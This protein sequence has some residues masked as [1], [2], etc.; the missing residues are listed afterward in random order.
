M[1]Q[2]LVEVR[3][4]RGKARRQE[5][6]RMDAEDGSGGGGNRVTSGGRDR[7]EAGE[8]MVRKGGLEPPRVAP[9]DPKSV[10]S[11]LAHPTLQSEGVAAGRSRCAT[12]LTPKG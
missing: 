1:P 3:G 4:R 7:G 12:E 11:G 5:A 6:G 9:P 8:E 10:L 2:E